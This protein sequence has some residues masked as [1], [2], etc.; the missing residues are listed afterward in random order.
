MERSKNESKTHTSY[1]NSLIESRF[2]VLLFILRM[3]GFQLNTK[4][5]S[6]PHAVYNVTIFA[7]FYITNI[8]VGVDTFVHRQDLAY[9]K[10]SFRMLLGMLMCAWLHFSVR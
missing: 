6:R 4:S 2:K 8:C 9:A 5:V 7:C 1:S 3:G 10:K